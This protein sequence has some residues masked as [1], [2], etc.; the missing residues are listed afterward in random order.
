M[1]PTDALQASLH[2]PVYVETRDGHAY[3]GRL[4]AFD[5]HLNLVLASAEEVAP[6]G[7]AAP[8]GLALLRGDAVVFVAP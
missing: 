6:D 8:A 5:Q 2:R 7:S 1:K 3:R 4:E